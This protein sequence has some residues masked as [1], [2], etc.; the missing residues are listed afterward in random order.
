MV[1]RPFYW[2]PCFPPCLRL[3][4]V[5]SQTAT[6]TC[7]W[8]VGT[9]TSTPGFASARSSTPWRGSSIGGTCW[10]PSRQFINMVIGAA[11]KAFSANSVMLLHYWDFDISV[12]DLNFVVDRNCPQWSETSQFC[13]RECFVKTYWLWHRQSHSTRHD[14]HH[15]RLAGIYVRLCV[16]ARNCLRMSVCVTVCDL[17]IHVHTPLRHPVA[18]C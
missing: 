6:S 13:D 10:K 5:R 8:S 17:V 18:V 1:L 15:E 3:R 14:E 12:I 16:C 4:A 11:T 2:V 9:L 7:W